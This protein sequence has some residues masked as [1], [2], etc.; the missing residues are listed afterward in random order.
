MAIVTIIT[1]GDVRRMFAGRSVAVVTR[2]A[3]TQHLG[4]IDRERWYP[5]RWVVAV[6]ANIGRQ[7]VRRVFASRRDAVVT[8]DAAARDVGMVEVRR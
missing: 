5:Y 8:V 2:T 7:Y 3:T 4:V 1:A 6:L